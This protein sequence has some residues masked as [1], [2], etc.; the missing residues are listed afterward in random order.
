MFCARKV[1]THKQDRYL[2]F[3]VSGEAPQVPVLSRISGNVF[4]RRLLETYVAE[5]NKDPTNGEDMVVED[6]V[7]IKTSRFVRP[8]PPNATSIPSLLSIFQNEWDALAMETYQVK[9]QLYQTRQE[10]STALY[11]HDAACR[12]I[13]RITKERDEARDALSKV[14]QNINGTD[15]T[16]AMETD[17][18]EMI[19]PDSIQQVVES[20]LQQESA[21][22]KKRKVPEGW[23][24]A[25]QLSGLK[26]H[27]GKKAELKLL[28]SAVAVSGGSLSA[29]HPSGQFSVL[30]QGTEWT[31]RGE[32]DQELAIS[33]N[34]ARKSCVSAL[35]KDVTD[36]CSDKRR[37]D[38]SRWAF[39]SPRLCGWQCIHFSSA[40][41]QGRSC[42]WPGGRSNFQCNVCRKWFLARS[43]SGK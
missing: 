23:T 29:T 28:A 19:I 14:S 31:L 20:T 13:A 35:R 36:S 38:T 34:V 30:A 4:E 15:G 9:Q 16:Q 3:V 6:I 21:G 24:T 18:A 10:L 12:V 42:L 43:G 26:S 17:I 8:R 7:E 37:G 32:Q 25:E 2:T 33:S 22:R 39:S 5:N 1:D 27:K 11:Q 40:H 41:F